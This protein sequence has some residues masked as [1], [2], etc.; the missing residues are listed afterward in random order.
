MTTPVPDTT[1]VTCPKCS[2]TS[3]QVIEV[4][5]VR[6]VAGEVASVV[7]VGLQTS[8][9]T[10][11]LQKSHAVMCLRCGEKWSPGTEQERLIRAVNGQ[12]GEEEQRRAYAVLHPP[13]YQPF[14]SR[15]W[16]LV[17]ALTIGFF[18]LGIFLQVVF[19]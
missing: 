12:F 7:L 9:V 10:G 5:R 1:P 8:A 11:S 18:A 15:F 14:G 16:K 6:S 2:S 17:G 4:P 3:L 13:P 19:N